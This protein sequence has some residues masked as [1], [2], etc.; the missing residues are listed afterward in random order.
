MSKPCDNCSEPIKT[1]TDSTKAGKP[2]KYDNACTTQNF[3]ANISVKFQSGSTGSFSFTFNSIP[4]TNTG[5]MPRHDD[6]KSKYLQAWKKWIVKRPEFPN[7]KTNQVIQTKTS[8]TTVNDWDIV[9]PTSNPKSCK[10]C[11]FTTAFFAK[12]CGCWQK[13]ISG[14]E[15]CGSC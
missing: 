14:A 1:G 8:I 11:T 12:L 9:D 15:T 3:L 2:C 4:A 7:I 5:N 13:S 10:N 6:F